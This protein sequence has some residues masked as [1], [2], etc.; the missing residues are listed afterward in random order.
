M[1]APRDKAAEGLREENA[2]KDVLDSGMPSHPVNKAS[3][4]SGKVRVKCTVQ[5]GHVVISLVSRRQNTVAD[6]CKGGDQHKQNLFQKTESSAL[7]G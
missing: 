5:C 6:T 1:H 7:M 3:H 4:W 2:Q